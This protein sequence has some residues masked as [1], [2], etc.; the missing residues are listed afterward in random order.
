MFIVKIRPTCELLSLW[1]LLPE[2]INKTSV[3]KFLERRPLL[4]CEAGLTFKLDWVTDVNWLMS[5]VEIPC[6][7]DWLLELFSEVAQVLLQIMV[8]SIDT[9]IQSC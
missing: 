5:H 9:I 6:K 2:D 3:Q 4:L 1:V 8:P 7:N